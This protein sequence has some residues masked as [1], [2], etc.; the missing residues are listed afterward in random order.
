MPVYW[1][2][3]AGWGTIIMNISWAS[4]Y[5]HDCLRYE[6][7]ENVDESDLSL[8][9]LWIEKAMD[10]WLDRIIYQDGKWDTYEFFESLAD[11]KAIMEM[12]EKTH[13]KVED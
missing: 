4:D 1:D 3:R 11:D 10:K 6:V 12:I 8:T 13:N 2:T 7:K 9:Y 5:I